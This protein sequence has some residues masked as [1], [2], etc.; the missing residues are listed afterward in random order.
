MPQ[1]RAWTR[2]LLFSPPVPCN[3][4]PPP[5]PAAIRASTAPAALH[6]IERL[7]TASS[8][9]SPHRATLHRIERLFTASSDSSPHRAALH[10]QLR[11]QLSAT[12][13]RRHRHPRLLILLGVKV[14]HHARAPARARH[15][16]VPH[17]PVTRP[18]SMSAFQHACS[19]PDT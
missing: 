8:G 11:L 9:S 19:R 2:T 7:F 16:I 13:C 10:Q 12:A 18:T 15:N 3:L 14:D 6:R 17:F 4:P 1:A 5:L